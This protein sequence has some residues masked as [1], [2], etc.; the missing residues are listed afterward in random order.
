MTLA[1]AILGFAFCMPI[2]NAPPPM[3]GGAASS[4]QTADTGNPQNQPAP[5]NGAAAKPAPD[6]STAP[7][8]SASPEHPAKKPV[9]RKKTEASD[10]AKASASSS[11]PASSGNSNHSS[12]SGNAEDATHAN[13]PKNCPPEKI[14]VR[15]GGTSEPSIQLAGSGPDASQ[16]RD[17]TNQMLSEAEGNLKKAAG[18]QL[19][20]NQQDS[21]T[22]VRQFIAESKTALAAGDVESA[23]TLAW[24]AKLLSDDLV[25]PPQ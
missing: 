8:T 16:K 14:I 6:Q 11:P 22:Q 9:H 15:Q 23:R 2:W 7:K 10:C 21:V 25:K 3:D 20:S 12:A 13:P 4:A 24:K 5:E 1:V 19:S 18:Q 17:A